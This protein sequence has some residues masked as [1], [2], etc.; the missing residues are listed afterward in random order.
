MSIATG[1]VAHLLADGT[2]AGIVGDRVY[3]ELRPQGSDLP[4]I[5]YTHIND[6]RDVDMAGPAPLVKVR[7]QVDCWH[8]SSAGV[9]ALATAVRSALN[10]VGIL[11]PKLLGAEPVQLVL[12]EDEGDLLSID[13]DS[14][15][16]RVSQDWIITY[17]E[18]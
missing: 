18:T 17:L 8:T 6:E 3:H 15:E 12:L 5:V 14:S 16:R 4:A 10:G 7:Y 9:A 11:S 1:L 13:G 2:V